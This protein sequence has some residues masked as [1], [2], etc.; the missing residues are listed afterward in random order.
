MKV[1]INIQS[2][3]AGIQEAEE[4]KNKIEDLL[5]LYGLEGSVQGDKYTSGAAYNCVYRKQ[6]KKKKA[7]KP[8]FDP[9]YDPS[10][11]FKGKPEAKKEVKKEDKK[12][13]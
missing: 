1:H 5:K 12:E 4:L 10:Q 8:K 7:D 13:E 9:K 11:Y 6:K 2:D 3:V